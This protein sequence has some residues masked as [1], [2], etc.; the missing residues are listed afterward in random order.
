MAI[1]TSDLSRVEINIGDE[2][3]YDPDSPA[4]DGDLDKLVI[5]EGSVLELQAEAHGKPTQYHVIKPFN[6]QKV[7]SRFTTS[8]DPEENMSACAS[9]LLSQGFIRP[10]NTN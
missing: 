8:E 7:A 9:Y 4:T 3:E 6:F 10:E 1:D 5:P 2:I